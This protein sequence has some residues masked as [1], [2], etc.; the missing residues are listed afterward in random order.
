M[1]LTVE[2]I[3]NIIDGIAPCSLA[4]PWDNCGMSAGS[5]QWPVKKILVGLDPC[6]QVMRAARNWEADMVLTHHPLFI[7]PEKTID[8]LHMPGSAIAMAAREQI[9][10][11][12]AHTNLDKAQNGLNDLFASRIGVV[13]THALLPD[14][15]ALDR[16]DN[17]KTGIGRIGHPASP[18]TL[19][20]LVD[21][22]KTRLEI[23]FVRVVGDMG[24]KVEKIALCTGSGGSLI[25]DF[26]KSGADLYITGDIKYHDARLVEAYGRALID[27][28]HFASEI[29]A[30]DLLSERMVQAASLAGYD[31]EIKGFSQET[32]PFAT[33]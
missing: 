14:P 9:A 7:S 25:S 27:V 31:L 8:F 10:I 20:R 1:T 5:L 2:K 28:G 21:D 13:C 6:M 11:V 12:C 19:A 17:Q 24:M 33:V 16:Q 23:P 29:A 32:D 30:V 3:L 15:R 22:I 4:E 18:A 26:I